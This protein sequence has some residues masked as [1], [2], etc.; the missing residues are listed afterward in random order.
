MNILAIDAGNTRVKWGW[1]EAGCWVHQSWVPS[2]EAATLG[3]ALAG[4]SVP[5]RIV[6]SNVAGSAVREHIAAA[7]APFGIEPLWIKSQAQ[8][9][10]VRSGY[11][12]PA[13]LGS[14]RW[15]ALI[16]AWH[17][18]NGPC[19]VVNAG[20]AMTVDALSG[21]GLF[22]GGIIV[23][24]IELMRTALA[25]STA[26][27]G[28][29][30]GRFTYFPDGTADAIMSGAINALAGSIERMVRFMAETGEGTALVVVSGGAA[31]LLA[32]HLNA[33]AEFV[34]NLVLEGLACIAVDHSA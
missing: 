21:E 33:R 16:G 18:F 12:D 28:L 5:D 31:A 1:A 30:E 20:T 14:D 9:C 19:V 13:Q 3:T 6:V 23:P 17:L 26:Q 8:Q 29:E 25:H 4:L 7:L 24:G 22:L 34:D 15:A 32:P 2:S 10:G 27:L 11:G